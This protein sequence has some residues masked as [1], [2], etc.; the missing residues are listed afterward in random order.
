MSSSIDLSIII[1]NWNTKDLLR[2]CLN[3]VYSNGDYLTIEVFVVDNN[4]SDGSKQMI[5]ES[6]PHVILIENETNVGFSVANN[7][8]FPLC[9]SNLVMLLN[10]DTRL[11]NGTFNILIDYMKEHPN[12]GAVGPK[13]IHPDMRLRVLS[14]GY[15]PTLKT[16]FNQY[17]FLST[18]FPNLNTFRGTN[19]IM[20]IHDDINREVE[21]LSGACILVRRNIIDEIGGLNEEWFMYAEDMEWCQRMMASGWKIY[22]LPEAV[23]EHRMGASSDQNKEVST[24][25]VKSLRS[26]FIGSR[27]PSRFQLFIFD[28]ILV[29]GLFLRAGIYA[30]RSFV[31]KK[32]HDLWKSEARKFISYAMSAMQL[33]K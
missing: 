19:L 3:S 7:Q 32:K 13:I 2:D 30:I 8:V 11:S 27:N 1:V 6:F 10:P 25:W 5:R 33:R 12:A 29:S 16:M 23:I 17:F 28:V 20:G 9:S 24:M 31:N 14:C 15:Q 21:W 26:Y 18:L 22:H 4:S